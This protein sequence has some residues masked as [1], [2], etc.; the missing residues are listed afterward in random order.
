MACHW[1]CFTGKLAIEP[2]PASEGNITDVSEESTMWLKLFLW[3]KY[4]SVQGVYAKIY[5]VIF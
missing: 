5:Q 3:G 4:S 1:F 2:F